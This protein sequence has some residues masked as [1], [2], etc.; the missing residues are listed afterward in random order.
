MKL[1]RG[2]SIQERFDTLTFAVEN[3]PKLHGSQ[4]SEAQSALND[5]AEQGLQHVE[6]QEIEVHV[7]FSVPNLLTKPAGQVN[8]PQEPSRMCSRSTLVA[9]DGTHFRASLLTL[10]KMVACSV[11][12]SIRSKL[13]ESYGTP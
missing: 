7:L 1:P 4:I 9:C 8:T 11:S 10:P 13:R 12:G 6:R 2:H 3:M 5:P